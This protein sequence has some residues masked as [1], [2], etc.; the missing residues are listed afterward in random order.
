MIGIDYHGRPASLDVT[1]A[2]LSGV[3]VRTVIDGASKTAGQMSGREVS[4]MRESVGTEP[5]QSKK[6]IG[7]NGYTESTSALSNTRFHMTAPPGALRDSA[8]R[9]Q[10]IQ[11][12]A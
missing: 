3:I 4:A 9:R 11:S 5:G 2:S 12:V 1:A 10:S 8:L 7:R 6:S